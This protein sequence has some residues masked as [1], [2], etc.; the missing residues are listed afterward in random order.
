MAAKEVHAREP[1]AEDSQEAQATAEGGSS[2]SGDGAVVEPEQLLCSITHV[3]FRDPVFVPGSGN[4][5]ERS[6]LLQYW[7]TTPGP[8]RDPLS[9]VALQ[10]RDVHTNWGL[11]R[12]VQRFLDLHP[13]Y[14]PEGWPDRSVPSQATTGAQAAGSSAASTPLGRQWLL[15]LVCAASILLGAAAMAVS[16]PRISRIPPPGKRS[17]DFSKLRPPKGSRLEVWEE[18]DHF[19]AF[20]PAHGP[21]RDMLGPVVFSCVWLSLTAVWTWGA[22]RGE[23]P[24]LF[25]AF[26]IP[27]WWAGLTMLEGSLQVPFTSEFLV[28]GPQEYIV[29]LEILGIEVLVNRGKLEDLVGPPVPFCLDTSNKCELI[30]Y[31][32]LEE[33]SFGGGALHMTEVKWLQKK[34][35]D[36]LILE[37]DD[38]NAERFV[39][40]L[41][42]IP[43]GHTAKKQKQTFPE[44]VTLR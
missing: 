26:S 12:D 10:G 42:S 44:Q 6:A 29:A 39:T 36:Y 28:M 25:A 30:F 2:S 40:S 23:A 13:A 22:I 34:I 8:P 15:L 1:F 43:T 11:R 16:V 3:M 21:G 14:V 27:F 4:S 24:K 20:R 32:G 31:E 37:A 18:D 41:T 19:H 38:T 7:A 9:N 5:Y 33:R 35:Q 17:S